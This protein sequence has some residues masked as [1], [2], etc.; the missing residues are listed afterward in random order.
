METRTS[1]LL[2][3]KSTCVGLKSSET[4][5]PIKILQAPSTSSAP[6]RHVN[7]ANLPRN[8]VWDQT[9]V[10]EAEGGVERANAAATRPP[11]LPQADTPTSNW[12]QMAPMTSGNQQR[13]DFVQEQDDDAHSVSSS[14]TAR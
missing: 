4:S 2:L 5:V 14:T 8:P 13:L 3:F 9:F 12:T 10:E 11:M 6:L 1:T 7:T